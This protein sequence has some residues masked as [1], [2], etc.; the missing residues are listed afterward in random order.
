MSLRQLEKLS[1]VATLARDAARMRLGSLCRRRDE[2]GQQMVALRGRAKEQ[3][4]VT[5]AADL[6]ADAS[7]RRH[8]L[9]RATGLEAEA[10]AIES[11]IR[12][13]RRRL[14]HL[15]GRVSA[16]AAVADEL[17]AYLR[18]R[19]ERRQEDADIKCGRLRP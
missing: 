7:W 11:E 5:S 15:D 17:R 2:L 10:R 8:L 12:A 18:R 16:V 4:P 13:E 9:A 19:A 6:R 14:M 3:H 1:R